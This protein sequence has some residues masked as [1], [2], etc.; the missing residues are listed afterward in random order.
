MPWFIP[1]VVAAGTAAYQAIKGAKQKREAR[2]IQAEANTQERS[3]LAEARRMAMTGLPEAQ[4][5]RSL[6]QIYRQQALG[7][8]GLRDRRS[9]LAGLP[10]LQQ[11]TNDALANLNAQDAAARRSAELTALNQ[12]NRLASVTG[13]RAAQV[14]SSG[15][16][17]TGAAIQN[18]SN[19]ANVSAMASSGGGFNF[20]GGDTGNA[21]SV[22]GAG[23]GMSPSG[24]R[25][26]TSL[27][28]SGGYRGF[29]N[30]LYAKPF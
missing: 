27:W 19:A 24:F 25:R 23:L 9:A 17:L 12:G 16:A 29:N 3:N 15:E 14:R 18:L 30:N 4:Y 6:Q 21:S 11:S 26:N 20:G 8:S 7:L 28:G 13:E 2:K 22:S 10:A 1:L 5:Q